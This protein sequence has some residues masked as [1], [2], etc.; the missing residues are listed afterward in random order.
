MAFRAGQRDV[1]LGG[2]LVGLL[3]GILTDLVVTAGG[4]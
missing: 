3:L 1:L 2:I 4:A